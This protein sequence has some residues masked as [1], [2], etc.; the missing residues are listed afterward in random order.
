MKNKVSIIIPVYNTEKYIK[1]CIDSIINQTYKNIE[2]IIVNDGSTDKTEKILREYNNSNIIYIEQSN[3]GV[4]SARNNGLKLATGKYVVFI[5]SDD[6]CE[7]NMIED[8]VKDIEN[9]N[10]ELAICGFNEIYK[11]VTKK[12]LYGLLNDIYNREKIE[13]EILKN[14]SIRGFLWNKIFL[15]EIIDKYNISFDEDI[16]MCEDLLFCVKYLQETKH[17]YVNNKNL[18]NYRQRKTSA[19]GTFS[20]KDLS[21]FNSY[22][23]MKKINPRISIYG[24][25][26]YCYWYYKFYKNLKNNNYIKNVEQI[27]IIQML[28]SKQIKIKTKVISIINLI[29]PSKI[30]DYYRNKKQKYYDYYE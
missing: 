11:N 21:L 8:M 27:S 14:N 2:I 10:V 15:K 9:N 25:D 16:S 3:K 6:F 22:E 28:K 30:C 26:I 12:S 1:Q 4:S 29:L 18:Y 24:E 5:D 23:R 7:I 19:I 13:E 17:V 20:K